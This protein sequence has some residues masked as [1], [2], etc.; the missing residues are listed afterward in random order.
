MKKFFILL[1]LFFSA[2]ANAFFPYEAVVY[3]G[4]CLA[5][6]AVYGFVFRS[7]NRNILI[8]YV[9][10]AAQG[11]RQLV[12]KHVS[13]GKDVGNNVWEYTFEYQNGSSETYHWLSDSR[14][15]SMY[16]QVDGK[17]IVKDGRTNNGTETPVLEFCKNN[18]P[19][20][21]EV[22]A[23][24]NAAE[25]QMGFE[26]IVVPEVKTEAQIKA[27]ERKQALEQKRLDAIEEKRAA[28]E[29]KKTYQ[30]MQSQCLKYGLIRQ[31]CATAPD[32]DRCMAIRIGSSFSATTDKWCLHQ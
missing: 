23:H 16:V 8:K 4:N 9:N 27:E 1:F 3:S 31:T 21:K 19:V 6:P 5:S 22:I 2:N 11:K 20:F 29:L 30:N 14:V 24:L 26:T 25:D 13:S 12:T 32:Y 28:A 18:T 7:D 10:T 15:K 17:V